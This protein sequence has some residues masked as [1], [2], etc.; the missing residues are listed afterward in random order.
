LK[1]VTDSK[2][3]VLLVCLGAPKQERW[4]A[5]HRGCAGHCV[6]MGLGGSL[7]IWAGA[8]KR[9]PKLFI[10]LNAEWLW[11]LIRQPSRIGRILKLPGI[12]RLA[13]KERK[14]NDAAGINIG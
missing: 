14:L 2:A 7:D 6:M 13:R 8:V 10:K 4:M 3:D 5:E 9:A 11:R 12:Y 1:N